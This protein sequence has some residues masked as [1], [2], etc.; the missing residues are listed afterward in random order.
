M[1]VFTFVL[2]FCN[3]YTVGGKKQPPSLQISKQGFVRQISGRDF[4]CN[5]KKLS[6]VSGRGANSLEFKYLYV[7]QTII[8]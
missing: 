7:I 8:V 6:T 4:I 5:F 3:T 2:I 1:P